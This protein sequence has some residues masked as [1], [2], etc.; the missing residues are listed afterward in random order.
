[1][2]D[3]IL[4]KEGTVMGQWDGEDVNVLKEELVRIK[5]YLRQQG[6]RDKVEPTGIPHQDQLPDDLRNFT[7]YLLWGCDNNSRCLVGSG[8]NRVESVESIREFYANSIAKDALA[9]HQDTD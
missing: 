3:N 2:S 1:M 8:A 4:S 9:R 5:Q 6:S 7:A